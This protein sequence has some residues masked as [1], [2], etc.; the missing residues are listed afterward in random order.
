MEA[1]E[2]DLRGLPDTS[3]VKPTQRDETQFNKRAA[4]PYRPFARAR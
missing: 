2:A 3:A 4:R 1:T